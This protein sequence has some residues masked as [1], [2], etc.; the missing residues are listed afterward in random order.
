MSGAAWLSASATMSKTDVSALDISSA[1]C[2]LASNAILRAT[3]DWTA[4]RLDCSR[5]TCSACRV[6]NAITVPAMATPMTMD[7]K[8]SSRARLAA[9][10]AWSAVVIET[11]R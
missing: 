6:M 8:S 2:R 7:H 1:V 10:C 9:A 3:S 11:S 5:S 4:S